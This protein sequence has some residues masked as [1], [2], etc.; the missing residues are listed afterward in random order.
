VDKKDCGDYWQFT[1][2]LR[3]PAQGEELPVVSFHPKRKEWN[4][5]VVIWA[6]G[7]GKAGLFGAGGAPRAEVKKLLDAGLAVL[8]ADLLYQ[9]EFLADG[10]PLVEQPKVRNNREFAGFTYG[11]NAPLF[12]RRVHD[13]LTLVSFVANDEH[14][15]RE[16]ALVGVNGAGPWVAAARAQAGGAVGRAFV[17]TR[18]FRFA[19][20]ASY[21]DPD[22]LPGAVKYGDLPGILSASAPHALWLAGEGG[23][24]PEAVAAAYAAAGKPDAVRSL[25][26]E[27]FAAAVEALLEP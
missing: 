24:I 4:G 25:P 8:G 7:A 9:G 19:K 21:R 18:G 14:A 13:L 2:I 20:L 12:A 15:P 17:D 26:A 11:Y 6:D 5:K 3:V 27:A 10:K 1:D 22:F 23:K 16:V